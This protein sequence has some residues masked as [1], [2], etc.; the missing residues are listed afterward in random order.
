MVMVYNGIEVAVVSHVATAATPCEDL[1]LS[2]NTNRM[3]TL[4]VYHRLD[5]PY[6]CVQLSNKMYNIKLMDS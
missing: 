6:P 5:S 2:Q 4:K 1:H 3:S